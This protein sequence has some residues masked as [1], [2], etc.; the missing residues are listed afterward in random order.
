MGQ[1]FLL[2]G[3]G[4]PGLAG[5]RG[6]QGQEA[7]LQQL[8][9]QGGQGGSGR[10]WLIAL[11]LLCRCGASPWI[12]E[13]GSGPCRAH[14][15]TFPPS[16]LLTGLCLLSPL[17]FWAC[18][19][20]GPPCF[21][22]GRAVGVLPSLSCTPALPTSHLGILSLRHTEHHTLDTYAPNTPPPQE[23]TLTPH[24]IG[25]QPDLDLMPAGSAASCFCPQCKLTFPAPRVVED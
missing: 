19:P 12:P 20:A 22:H 2:Q 21:L 6:C 5:L 17:T 14:Y 24:R 11:C 15:C 7:D 18:C 9:S 25:S 4:A 8:G 1:R 3:V 13:G 16:S 23:A 10:S